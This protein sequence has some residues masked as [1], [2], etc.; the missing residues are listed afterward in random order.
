MANHNHTKSDGKVSSTRNSKNRALT[1]Y[2]PFNFNKNVMDN[3][4]MINPGDT[5]MLDE[6]VE[7]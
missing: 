7:D 4:V 2:N 1:I 6:A 3:S 5:S